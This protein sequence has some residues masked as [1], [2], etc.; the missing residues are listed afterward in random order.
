MNDPLDDFDCS[1]F[2]AA[3]STR[4][5][6]RQGSG[7][8]VVILTE[9]PGITPDVAD[10]A[11]RVVSEGFSV[12]MPDLFGTPGRPFSNGYVL[13]SIVKG[14]VSREF[15]AFAREKTSP[16]TEWLRPLVADAHERVGGAAVSNGV[17]VVGMCFTGGFALALTVDPLVR[18][19]VMSQPSMPFGLTKRGK[20][21]LGLDP[22]DLAVVKDRVESE[23]LCVV[24]LRFTGDPLVPAERF[25]R[26][27]AEFGERF[28]A[29]EL[30]SANKQQ[31]SVLAIEYDPAPGSPTRNAYELVIDH[32][33]RLAPT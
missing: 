22:A 20:S 29:V 26:L 15:V 21:D 12:T 24:G 1:P 14:C 17:G 10:F 32:F 8:A 2:T 28:V 30:E 13:S 7:P 31:H 23:D 9:M 25:E 5:V 27:R 33:R 19:P 4:A 16:I 6:Y 3:G 11:R 18:V